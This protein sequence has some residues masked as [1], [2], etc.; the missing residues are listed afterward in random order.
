MLNCK[1]CNQPFTIY[2]EDQEMY[3]KFAVPAPRRCPRCRLI[4]RLM[5]RNARALYYRKCDRSGETILSSYNPSQPFPV[6]KP[7]IWWSDQWEAMDYARDYDFGKPF[8]AQFKELN[9]VVP[10]FS[11]FV[12][13]GTV[14]NCDFTNC[15]G[16]SKNCYL[17]F[18]TD[19]A[20]DS[21]YSNLLKRSKDMVDCSI[22]YDDEFCYQCV[23]C[24]ASYGL[25]YCQNCTGCR[26][27]Y[28]LFDC[29]SCNDCIGCINQRYQKFMIFNEQYSEAE[30][31]Q[32]KAALRLDTR[33]GVAALASQCQQFFG[34]HP[35]KNLQFEKNVN[36]V[37][38]YLYNSKN[39]FQCFDC[40]DLED[41][42]YCAKLSIGV[43]S[44]MDYNSW[45][46]RAELVYSC[47]DVGGGVYNL[48]FCW[49]IDT[50]TSDC[51]YCT[52]C[53]ACKDCFGCSGLQK[54]QYCILNKQYSEKEYF[55]LKEKII[56]KMTADGEY[57]EF[58]P[59]ELCPFAYNETIVMDYFPLTKD[60]A[61][62]AGYR[63]YDREKSKQPAETEAPD[64]IGEVADAIIGKVLA[65][66]DCQS[67]YKIIKQELDFCRRA[68]API[69]SQ[70]PDCRHFGRMNKRMPLSLITVKCDKCGNDMTTG[71]TAGAVQKV[72]CEECY[73]KEIY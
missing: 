16:F 13:N 26:D 31:N 61:L 17:T 53:I 50:K 29:K 19:Y 20:E 33:S 37:G 14:V 4:Q 47:S 49:A 57:G 12:S 43:K 24:Q 11:L 38:N 7:D 58:F 28:F 63:W 70:C 41:C 8:F 39:A 55:A 59:A 32:K 15:I 5:F 67:N 68:S 2:P 64:A 23:D 71:Y 1:N 46:D 40:S 62:K 34:K 72:Y 9:D 54:K 27:S 52:Q 45:G 69:P 42:R 65:C 10:H 18:E 66:R 60:E 22:C 73:Q 56:A 3:D 21:Y 6:Y 36:S 30:Y 35:H 48:K 51:E 25:R 44:C